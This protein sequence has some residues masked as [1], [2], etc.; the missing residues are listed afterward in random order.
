MSL[1]EIAAAAFTLANVWLATRQNMWTWP[2]GI[3]SVVLYAIVFFQARLYGNAALQVM[4]F[5]MTLHGWYE[6]MHGGVNHTELRVRRTTGR[7]WIGCVVAA[8]A[9]TLPILWLLQRFNGSAPVL[10]AVTTSMSMVSQWMLNEKLIENWWGWIVIDIISVPM[11][12][13]AGQR[14]TAALYAILGVLC[15][16]GLIG[17]RRSLESA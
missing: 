10:D 11:F 2:A 13:M 9:V 12:L 3:A 5:V 17:W 6:W 15:V 14:V 8:V 16:N 7:Q 4:Y 1:L